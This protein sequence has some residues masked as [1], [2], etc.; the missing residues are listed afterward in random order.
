M[1]TDRITVRLNEEKIKFL[2]EAGGGGHGAIS[3]GVAAVIEFTQTFPV[4][5]RAF[6][7]GRADPTQPRTW[8]IGEKFTYEEKKQCD[9]K[10]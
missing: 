8:G 1:A 3:R 9:A 7:N 5:F 6:L 4:S 10:D 2:E